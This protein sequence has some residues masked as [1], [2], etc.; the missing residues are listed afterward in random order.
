MTYILGNAWDHSTK[1]TFH[2]RFT[3][4]DGLFRL[5]ARDVQVRSSHYFEWLWLTVNALVA[6]LYTITKRH[7]FKPSFA[8]FSSRGQ[9][10]ITLAT[11]H[12]RSTDKLRNVARVQERTARFERIH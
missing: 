9:Y 5:R 7:H 1:K 3:T 11:D 10:C 8:H 6:S 12:R 4:M 2:V